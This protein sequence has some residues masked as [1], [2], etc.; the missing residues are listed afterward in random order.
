[1]SKYNLG[2]MSTEMQMIPPP[3]IKNHII[4]NH[5]SICDVARILEIFRSERIGE[6][7]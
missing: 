7:W 5:P 1:M 3:S 2:D 6:N 4:H